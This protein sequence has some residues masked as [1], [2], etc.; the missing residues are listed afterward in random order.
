MTGRPMPARFDDVDGADV[1][2]LVDHL[3]VQAATAFWLER[4]TETLR[5]L[6][7]A[8][9]MRLLD[10]GC[11]TG[12][13]VLAMGEA[14]GPGGEAV[15]VDGSRAMIEI[16]RS[17]A[18]TDAPVRFDVADALALP[19]EDGS[20][21]GVRCE[22]LLQHVGDPDRAL[23]EMARVVRPGAVVLAIEPDWDTLAVDGE[24]FEVTLAVC[25]RWADA[26]RSPWVGR[27][28]PERMARAGLT[29]IRATPNTSVISDRAFAEQQFALGDLAT[30]A[31]A[32]GDVSPAEAA[33]WLADLDARAAAGGFHASATYV[34][35]WGRR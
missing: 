17:R 13:D 8:P 14:V 7:A 26:I 1:R 12:A 30:A 25:R 29:D 2:E 22:R 3:D 31:A 23:A 33:A 27:E 24:P 6:E 10:V 9:G 34:T 35:A 5:L 28:L 32:D 20:F 21:D 19:F 11:G 18:P 16:A 4:K 15:G